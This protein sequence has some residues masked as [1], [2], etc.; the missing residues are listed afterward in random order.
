ML[1]APIYLLLQGSSAVLI[2]GTAASLLSHDH[3]TIRVFDFPRKQIAVGIVLTMAGL[4]ALGPRNA[5]SIGALVG[6]SVCLLYQID[7]VIQYTWLAPMEVT[8]ATPRRPETETISILAAN[9][10][11]DNRD[12]SQFLEVVE[13]EDPDVV[14]AIETDE[15]WTRELEALSQQ[16][17]HS[18]LHP[19][20]NAYGMCLFSKLPLQS[21]K[22]HQ[23]TRKDVPSIQAEIAV[24]QG[25]T[26][27]FW[28]VHPR[29][30]HP[31]HEPDTTYRDAELITLA[32]EIREEGGPTIVAGDLNDV[33]WS[34]TTDLFQ[35]IGGLLDP[36]RG[37]GFYNTFH[38]RYPIVRYP[39]DHTFHSEH[40][41]V[42]RLDVLRYI[43]SDHYPVLA[44]LQLD[45]RAPEDH[46]TP[47]KCHIVDGWAD[48]EMRKLERK[49]REEEART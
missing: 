21:A 2:G 12:S 48:Y 30:P 8:E 45:P 38:A 3:W 7:H 29:P 34:H 46:S 47:E 1:E 37:R 25:R 43:G 33:S 13:E 16:Y 17:E 23:L 14:L 44:E 39:L 36:R 26:I 22:V 31:I 42:R 19:Q 27:T 9:V 40:F 24:G 35:R 41:R 15:W 4:W 18:V 5:A 20:E 32:R 10:E 28:G 49:L 6:L 11:V